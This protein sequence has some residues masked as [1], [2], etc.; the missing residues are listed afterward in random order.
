MWTPRLV[1]LYQVCLRLV[2]NDCDSPLHVMVL[3]TDGS[4]QILMKFIES[5]LSN[6]LLFVSA[7]K[8]F[9]LPYATIS[10]PINQP[11]ANQFAAVW[12]SI[13]LSDTNHVT[14]HPSDIH[15]AYS[16][17]TNMQ[18]SFYHKFSTH[19]L[20]SCLQT[21]YNINYFVM[22]SWPLP[23]IIN[24]YD[25]N[26]QCKLYLFTNYFFLKRYDCKRHWKWNRL[27]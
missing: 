16:C 4:R 10:W 18:Y 8:I 2:A 3:C 27:K 15:P 9:N 20:T 6:L 14:V 12:L 25:P 17:P 11:S 26:I 23:T 5:L 21:K 1:K 24:D 7:Y 19:S 22:R 13:H